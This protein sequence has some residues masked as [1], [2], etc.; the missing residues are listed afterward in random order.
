M[1][2]D[3]KKRCRD[4]IEEIGSEKVKFLNMIEEMYKK[5]IIF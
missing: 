5:G 3:G 2:I 1:S 4:I